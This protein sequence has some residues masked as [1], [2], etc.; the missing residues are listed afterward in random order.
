VDGRGGIGEL[1]SMP[2]DKYV[3][4]Y[5]RVGKASLNDPKQSKTRRF[6]KFSK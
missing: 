1:K 4:G 3:R 2:N 5:N 6:G